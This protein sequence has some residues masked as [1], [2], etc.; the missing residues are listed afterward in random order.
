M[1]QT[2]VRPWQD[3]W[4]R[5][6][7][8]CYVLCALLLLVAAALVAVE[9]TLSPLQS[10]FFS[11]LGREMEFHVAPGPSAAIRFPEV[12]PF[13]ER[14]GYSALP[15]LTRR[16]TARDFVV[17]AQ[18]RMS[19]PMLD[20][21]DRGLFAPYPE[22]VEAGLGVL[23]CAGAELFRARYPERI[24]P[25]FEAIPGILV[26]SLLFIENRELLSNR[27]PTSNPA[28]EWRR[29]A[30]AV[31]GRALDRVG[32]DS[33]RAG[34]STLATQ[35]EKY[36]HSPGG[37]TDSPREKLRQMASA[38]LRAYRGGPDTTNVRRQ[39]VV[40]YL[41]T[42][43]FAARAGYGEVIGIGDG[44][45][46]W[47][48][49][50]FDA[51]NRL[52][53]G[54]ATEPLEQRALVFKEALSLLISQRRPSSYLARDRGELE[55]LTDAHL[56]L[57]ARAGV[58][59][60]ALRDAA[61]GQ[62]LA[63]RRG[64]VVPV[65]Q[66][67][68]DRKASTAIRTQ[69]AALLERPRLY[70]LDRLDLT[71]Q[72]TIDSALQ[73]RV[74]EALRDL[75][76]PAGA[77][78]AGLTGERLLEGSDPAA[79]IY[80][81]TLY[82]ATP[83]ANVVRVQT[84]NL[85]QPFDIN[86]GARLDLGS[87][88]KLRTLVTYLEIVARLHAE[89]VD[90]APDARQ[91]LPVASD[92]AIARWALD[93]FATAND[94]GRSLPAML[95][96]ALD[97]PYSANPNET[98]FT[99]G[100]LQRFGNFDPADDG[101]VV[102]VR[103]ALQ[104]SVNL[105]FVRLMRDIVRHTMAR[106]PSASATLLDQDD[107][108]KRREYLARFAEREGSEYLRQFHRKYRGRS[109]DAIE[110]LLVSGIRPTPKRLATLHRS[111]AP[112]ASLAEFSAFLRRNLP[113]GRIDEASIARLYRSQS[114]ERFDLA[115]RGFIA[116]V[117]PLEL[118]LAGYLRRHPEAKLQQ[119]LDDSRRERQAA[120]G[121]LF[122]T[123]RKGAQDLR[124]RSLVELEAFQQI[125]ASWRRLGFPFESLT[126]SYAT[127]LGSSA[128][129]PAALA[130]LMGIL[131]NDGE[132]RPVVRIDALRFAGDTPYETRFALRGRAAEPVLAPA[133][134]QAARRA[135]AL[136]IRGGTARRLDGV[137][138]G[139]DGRDLEVGGKTGTG[140]HRFETYGRGGVLLS[141]RVV[142]RSGTFVFH[143]GDRHF[144]TLTAHVRGPAAAGYRFTSALPT[145][146]LKTLQP[147]L[148]PELDRAA[149]VGTTCRADAPLRGVAPRAA[150]APAPAQ[151]DTGGPEPLDTSTPASAT[152]PDVPEPEP[153]TVDDAPEPDGDP[154]SP[155]PGSSTASD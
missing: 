53:G 9:I 107:D 45:W 122:K 150:P 62:R 116:G 93:Y 120:Y 39:L 30:R 78:A 34:G 124:I 137:F 129:R 26:D 2:P 84:D 151:R 97:R 37:V 102:T 69:L 50:D 135:L 136:V 87:T 95:E 98:F 25:S 71:A 83:Q 101:R 154:A 51:A 56:R 76:T 65:R 47:Y 140:D 148:Q 118:W 22:K 3:F 38:S 106:L 86:A 18:A 27:H 125:H 19:T 119:V 21:I 138:K 7:L 96:A 23:D 33:D 113:E 41:N 49:R 145:Q 94:D 143:L 92:D 152:Q 103:A 13:D 67:F 144:G 134:A 10:R 127:A 35:I 29:L 147:L 104:R 82:E 54:A 58:I 59:D 4:R 64:P 16:L 131:L 57:L 43:P 28:I 63:P 8:A 1:S 46:A 74:T 55:R 88:A 5:F 32:I 114:V 15:A 66:S 6:R 36:R 60:G 72:S 99:G 17:T 155:P 12:G 105:V 81:F 79:V 52:L 42:V 44:L 31:A 14:L 24:Y 75:A 61:L 80:S 100:G 141:S 111:I 153:G 11:E 146:V 110:T 126:P 68:I 85:D 20:V 133:V 40:D 48:G 73:R 149:R 112:D 109:P 139:P 132:R 130:E 115:D 121:W 77:R 70:E 90:L 89:L 108:P 128:D 91:A 142:S 117:H 123:R